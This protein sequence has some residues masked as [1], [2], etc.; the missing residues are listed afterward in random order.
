[1]GCSTAVVQ[2]TV[3]RWVV[4]SNP[5][6]P[7]G[8]FENC[9]N[10]QA[11]GNVGMGR[12]IAYYSDLGYTIS[13]PM[14]DCQEYD[15]VV[16]YPDG[17]KK[18]QVKTTRYKNRQGNYVVNLRTMGGSKSASNWKL[19]NNYDILWAI[20]E[21]GEIKVWTKEELGDQQSITMIG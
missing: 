4:G 14:N 3:N 1:M 11:Q 12:C 6:T 18:V 9:S 15:L 7:V 21:L 17:L 8:I 5:T 13:V 2:T 16:E 20:N 19:P 10:S